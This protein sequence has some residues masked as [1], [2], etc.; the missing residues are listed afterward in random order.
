MVFSQMG[1]PETLRVPLAPVLSASLAGAKRVA[2]SRERWLPWLT[3]LFCA[4]VTEA[5]KA[6]AAK[7]VKAFL[8]LI[9]F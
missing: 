2:C 8:I 6:M 7:K 9:L 1:L 5:N 4:K 3:M